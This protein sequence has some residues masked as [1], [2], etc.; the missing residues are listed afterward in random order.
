MYVF[1]SGRCRLGQGLRGW[2]VLCLWT[3]LGVVSIFHD[4]H[5]SS[6]G[7]ALDFRADCPGCIPQSGLTSHTNYF[8]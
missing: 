2:V 5:V 8:C 4:C 3:F 6:M 1:G 7:G